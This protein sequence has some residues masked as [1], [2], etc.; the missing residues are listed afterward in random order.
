M[1]YS[2]LLPGSHGGHYD[3][4]AAPV[5]NALLFA[6]EATNRH[7]P[8]TAAGALESGV[9]EA[10]RLARLYGRTRDVGVEAVL[11]ARATRLVGGGGK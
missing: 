10:T 7:H 4:L 5:D 9:R 3:A 2:Y 6:G 1:S 11:S 8:T